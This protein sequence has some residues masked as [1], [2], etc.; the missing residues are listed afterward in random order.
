MDV[1]YYGKVLK[2]CVKYSITK[3]R[4]LAKKT[5][6][7]IKQNKKKILNLKEGQK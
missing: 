6:K 4:V 2:L 3:Q 1:S 7:E 5:R